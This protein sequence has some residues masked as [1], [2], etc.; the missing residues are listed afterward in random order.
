M[1]KLTRYHKQGF[2]KEVRK[3]LMSLNK[4]YDLKFKKN[5]SSYI[6]IMIFKEGLYNKQRFDRHDRIFLRRESRRFAPGGR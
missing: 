6:S 2:P 1:K 5:V 3:Q 4:R